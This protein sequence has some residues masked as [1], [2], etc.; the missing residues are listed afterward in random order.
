[1]NRSAFYQLSK[2]KAF[3]LVA[4]LIIVGQII[5]VELGGAAFRTV[6]LNIADFIIIIISTSPI[7]FIPELLKLIS[8]D[9]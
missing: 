5:I 1:V 6:P 9:K 2:S 3:L 7:L 4:A 8:P